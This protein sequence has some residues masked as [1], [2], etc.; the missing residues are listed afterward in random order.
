MKPKN[1]EE[2]TKP[3]QFLTDL[4]VL[5]G[6]DEMEWDAVQDHALKLL[7]DWREQYASI[8]AKETAI[9][10][11]CFETF[12]GKIPTHGIFVEMMEDFVGNTYVEFIESGYLKK[13]KK[14]YNDWYTKHK[15][16]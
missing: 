15:E 2:I 5:L 6:S 16:G 13:F 9:G 10:F 1:A 12:E 3:E 8:K 4:M 7:K 14:L 11:A